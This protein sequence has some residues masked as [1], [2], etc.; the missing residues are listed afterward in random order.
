M[1]HR[2]AI[3]TDLQENICDDIR[4]LPWSWAKARLLVDFEVVTPVSWPLS[5]RNETYGHHSVRGPSCRQP[6]VT[7]FQYID[8]F[9]A[10]LMLFGICSLYDW[11]DYILYFE[12]ALK[13]N[14]EFNIIIYFLHVKLICLILTNGNKMVAI[15]IM[16]FPSWEATWK[17]R[18]TNACS[19]L[20][21][22]LIS[23]C[24]KRALLPRAS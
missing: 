20:A 9:T 16:S 1:T 12:M 19:P 7:V 15:I 14:A 13:L 22:I 24:R 4:Q 10:V 23:T 21:L 6:C 5:L 3:D 2:Q 18:G 8:S 11:Y 17:W